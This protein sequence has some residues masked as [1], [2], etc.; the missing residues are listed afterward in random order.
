MILLIE[1]AR[2]CS[3]LRTLST[4]FGSRKCAEQRLLLDFQ[5]R[6]SY[7]KVKAAIRFDILALS[8]FE[9]LARLDEV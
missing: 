5:R 1:A 3:G 6:L 8:S 2:R 7:P 4:Q 9:E